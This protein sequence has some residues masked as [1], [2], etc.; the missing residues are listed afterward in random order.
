MS[1]SFEM[2]F[3]S[4]F[5]PFSVDFSLRGPI[6]TKNFS[7]APV[8]VSFSWIAL[9]AINSSL[10]RPVAYTLAWSSKSGITKL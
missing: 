6:T 7:V 9:I 8:A 10:A 2:C 3:S 5:S 4:R 1:K